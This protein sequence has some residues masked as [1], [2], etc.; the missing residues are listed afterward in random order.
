MSWMQDQ[1]LLSRVIMEELKCP[2]CLEEFVDPKTLSCSH[3][4]C[5]ACLSNMVEPR[6]LGTNA[7]GFVRCPACRRYT[8]VHP[9]AGIQGLPT[10][11]IVKNLISGKNRAIEIRE[12]EAGIRRSRQALNVRKELVTEI[13]DKSESLSHQRQ[14]IEG[15][16]TQMGE[17][18]VQM[19]RENQER[20]IQE[21]H[22]KVAMQ[23]R[24]LRQKREVMQSMT[25]HANKILERIEEKVQS[26]SSRQL[27]EE[28]SSILSELIDVD[29][30]ELAMEIPEL[31][32]IAFTPTISENDI[33]NLTALGKIDCSNI[34]DHS[35]VAV[36]IQDYSHDHIESIAFGASGNDNGKFMLPWGVAVRSD[37]CITVADHANNRIQ[38]FDNQGVFLQAV[39]DS[40]RETVRL[41]T[42]ITFDLDHNLITFD[43]QSRVIKV[44][45]TMGQLIRKIGRE[46]DFSDG[47][48]GLS[49]DSDGRIIVTDSSNEQVLVYHNHGNLS[50]KFGASGKNRLQRPSCALFRHGQFIVSDTFNHC[51]KVYN[52]YG[53]YTHQIG[54]PG[55]EAGQFF[56][57]RGLAVD[58]SNNILVCDS[59]NCR[60]QVLDWDGNFIKSFGKQGQEVGDFSM[61]YG[62]AIGNHG[63]V[64]V[65]DCGNN[66]FQIFKFPFLEMTL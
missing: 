55:N 50:L 3:T 25:S 64:V 18:I 45:D 10:N 58:A 13:V 56:H 6:V 46:G 60:V 28:K 7:G 47:V 2:V 66:R 40:E 59:G 31:E 36:R 34:Q 23:Q 57:P 54:R 32:T 29:A 65:S 20:L 62:I 4:V 15:D 44:L 33:E 49:I 35:T 39:P 24:E 61:P 42:G 26:L 38:M 12:L 53:I 27:I 19:V 9:P 17:K 5:T 43:R 30:I 37:G 11:H 8:E 14:Q 41:P 63:E 22:T 16:I 1:E 52:R 48:D 21:L 51:L